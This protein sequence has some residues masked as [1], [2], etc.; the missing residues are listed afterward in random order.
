MLEDN[1]NRGLL[2]VAL[3]VSV[4]L[5]AAAAAYA[6]VVLIAFRPSCGY[7]I[8]ETPSP[9]HSRKAVVVVANCGATVSYVTSVH[10][11]GTRDTFDPGSRDYFFAVKGK[12]DIQII[13][14]ED[15]YKFGAILFNVR[16]EKPETIYR[17][18]AV[19]N[20]HRIGY[21]EKQ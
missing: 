3:G 11:V 15:Y 18:A 10:L 17:Q 12:N 4:G 9:D 16:H 13:W 5:L 19:W 21:Q 20:A 2:K 14:T 1:K 6:A 7:D 8:K